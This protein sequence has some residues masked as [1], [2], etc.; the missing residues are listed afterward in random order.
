MPNAIRQLLSQTSYNTDGST[1]VWDFSFAGGYLEGTHVKAYTRNPLSGVIT[2]LSLAPLGGD[3]VGPFQL[4][5]TPALVIGSELTIYRDTP[6]DVPLVNFADKASFSEAALD[7]NAKQAVFVAAE[8][9]DSLATAIESVASTAAYVTLA[10]SYATTAQAAAATATTQAGLAGGSA[11]AAAASAIAANANALAVAAS[12]A[13]I[14]GGPV[15][16]FNGRFG[17]VTL[18]KADV[19]GTG[20]AKAD[21]GLGNVDNTADVNK[22]VSTATQTALNL[23][24]SLNSPALAGFKN[25]L[26]NG[27]LNINQRVVSGTVT[28][29]AGAYGHDRFKAGASGCTYTFSKSANVTTLTI[30]AGSLIQVVEGLNLETGTYCLSWSGTVQGKIGAGSFAA[31]GVTGSI[32]GGTNTNIEFNTGTLSLPQLEKGPTA[33]A[34]DYRDYGR[35]LMMCQRYYLQLAG[36]SGFRLDFN[37]AAANY[38]G[39]AI[40][41]FPVPMRAAPTMNAPTSSNVNVNTATYA[42]DNAFSWNIYGAATA[43]GNCSIAPTTA[44][45]F[46]AEL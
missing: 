40:F 10:E 31:S 22:P 8:S 28:L 12:A 7:L 9:S 5:I 13:S 2:N 34:F 18:L 23:K 1:T 30:S 3:L 14:A 43:A 32:T 45:T 11:T 42:V 36:N 35:E 4:R 15:A 20:L 6:K 44:I 46:T 29:V 16:S 26:I 21:I 33:T 17:V 38:Q 24:A 19:I 25:R 41:T 37:G 27:Q 39:K